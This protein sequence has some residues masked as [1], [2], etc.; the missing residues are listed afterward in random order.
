LPILVLSHHQ[1]DTF[2]KAYK[3]GA[4]QVISKSHLDAQMLAYSILSSIDRKAIENEIHMRDEILKAVNKRRRDFPYTAQLGH[5][6]EARSWNRWAKPPNRI[7]Y[8]LL[9]TWTTQ[10][11][12]LPVYCKRNGGPMALDKRMS[13]TGSTALI[14]SAPVSTD[15]S[16]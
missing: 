2:E 3:S 7:M 13:L 5:L 9:K 12:E 11:V 15:G 4:Q 1:N 10:K 16:S 8:P 14:T 6:P